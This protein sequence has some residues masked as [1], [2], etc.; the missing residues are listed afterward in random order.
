MGELIR[1]WEGLFRGGEEGQKLGEGG[2]AEARGRSW[3][4][5][6][7]EWGGEEE[8]L[9]GVDGLVEH[10]V[11]RLVLVVMVCLNVSNFCHLHYFSL[12]A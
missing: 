3:E 10:H 2:G 6:L 12:A 11:S 9:D 8:G 4:K 5:E 7:Q 1:E